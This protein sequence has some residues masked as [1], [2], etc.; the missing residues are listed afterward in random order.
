VTPSR[1]EQGRIR[2]RAKRVAERGS[3][4]ERGGLHED[5]RVSDDP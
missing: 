3:L 4:I 5:S 2:M 1:A